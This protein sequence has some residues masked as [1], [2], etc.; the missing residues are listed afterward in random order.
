MW[1]EMQHPHLFVLV[2]TL[3]QTKCRY[4]KCWKKSHVG[5]PSL[6][7]WRGVGDVCMNK[8]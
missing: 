1:F 6:Q 3:W 4:K 5:K 8:S 2:W 7:L